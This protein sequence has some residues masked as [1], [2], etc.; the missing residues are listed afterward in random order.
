MLFAWKQ[1]QL[2]G[3]S[4]SLIGLRMFE[5]TFVL[6]PIFGV[7]DFMVPPTYLPPFVEKGERSLSICPIYVSNLSPWWFPIFFMFI[8][9]CGRF[10]FW[11]AYFSNGLVQPPPTLGP[12][13]HE[14]WRFYTPKYG[15]YPLKMKVL[16]SHGSFY[17]IFPTPNKKKPRLVAMISWSTPLT[18]RF[19]P[20]IRTYQVTLNAE[21]VM[22][23]RGGE[24]GNDPKQ[25]SLQWDTYISYSF[26]D[27]YF[28]IFSYIHYIHRLSNELIPL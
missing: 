28:Y 14:K 15:L 17:P 22:K 4:M 23:G 1:V 26:F 19:D 8:P 2:V 16:G 24:N 3:C 21:P 10:T 25:R 6:V 12:Q 13:N 5:G 9:T 27:I 11:R 7:L 20:S 18:P